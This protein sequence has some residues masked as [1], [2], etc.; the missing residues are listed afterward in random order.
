MYTLLNRLDSADYYL[1][2]ERKYNPRWDNTEEYHWAQST[3]LIKKHDYENAVAEL[4]K[5]WTIHDKGI[6]EVLKNNVAFAASDFHYNK[7]VAEHEKSRQI[8]CPYIAAYC[9]NH[10]NMFPDFSSFIVSA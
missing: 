3:L 1:Q 10:V 7:S 5:M 9:D 8:P 6:K 2:L 4:E